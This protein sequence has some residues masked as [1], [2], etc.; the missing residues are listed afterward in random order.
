MCSSLELGTVAVGDLE[1]VDH[2]PVVRA[3][4]WRRRTSMPAAANAVASAASSP[5][6]SVQRTSHTVCHG[7]AC[8][9]TS[10]SASGSGG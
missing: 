3:S 2:E 5:G 7:D 9:S 4:R 6:R 1:P 8:R 10:T